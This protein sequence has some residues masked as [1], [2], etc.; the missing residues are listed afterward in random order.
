MNLYDH[1]KNSCTK[2]LTV[3][4][5]LVLL[6]A[7]LHADI[8]LSTFSSETLGGLTFEDG[9]LVE[10]DMSGN[11]STLFFDE[12]LF[13][14]NENID[15]IHILDSGNIVLSTRDNATLGGLSFGD[16]DLV[17]YNTSTNAATIFLNE[18]VF[19]QNE[20]I[21]AL[22]IQSNGSIVLSTDT[23]ATIDGLSF[24]EGDL[25]EYN[26]T[27][28]TAS[29][30]LSSTLFGQNIDIDA[31]HI[32]D[33]GDYLLSSQ[34]STTLAGVTFSGGDVI[35]Y[36]ATTQVASIFMD[37]SLF[38]N[39]ANIDAIYGLDGLGTGVPE[40]ATIAI[41]SLG[42]LAILAKRK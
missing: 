7:P 42:S 41:L 30:L 34:S 16:G 22:F 12:D 31:V 35:R 18:S 28:D 27:T 26:P 23:S 33:D 2:I 20:D 13:S 4:A 1:E 10:Y 21:D 36:N 5:L 9:D 19:N 38:S 14:G 24:G 17:E 11:S 32:L 29:V 8:V 15:A 40:P 3:L 39:D 37:E 6:A 25:I